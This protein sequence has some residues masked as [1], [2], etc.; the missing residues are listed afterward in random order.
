MAKN[1]KVVMLGYMASGKSTV[2]KALANTLNVDFVDLD[3]AIEAA[4]RKPIPEIF[5]QKGELFFRK[6]ETKVLTDQL[7][8][9]TPFVLALGGGTPCYGANMDIITKNASH[10]FYL[11]LSIGNLIQRISKEKEQRP[12]VAAIR[13]ED[14]PEFI[15]KH[16]FERNLFYA[17]AKTTVVGDG[18]TVEEIVGELVK[19]LG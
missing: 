15:G 2:G 8:K 1:L 10:S 5:A 14:L 3:Q 7:A 6:M 11:K 13:D 19:D 17:K 9:E 12:M 18:L 16:L 4:V